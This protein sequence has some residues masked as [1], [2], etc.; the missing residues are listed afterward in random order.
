VSKWR[1]APSDLEVEAKIERGKTKGRV[2]GG[3][4]KK[5]CGGRYR[6]GGGGEGFLVP[7]PGPNQRTRRRALKRLG[8]C[9]PKL[10][11]GGGQRRNRG[12]RGGRGG[13]TRRGAR[14]AGTRGRCEKATDKNQERRNFFKIRGHDGEEGSPDVGPKVWPRGAKA[15][16]HPQRKPEFREKDPRGSVKRG[17]KA[18]GQKFACPSAKTGTTGVGKGRE[19]KNPV[20][21]ER[22]RNVYTPRVLVLTKHLTGLKSKKLSQNTPFVLEGGGGGKTGVTESE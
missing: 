20:R 8:V 10:G 17:G 2:S 6:R 22:T 19:H 4:K 13:G 15:G 9:A 3:V 21:L 12:E 16:S 7:K 11:D 14:S 1:G 5:A 18:K